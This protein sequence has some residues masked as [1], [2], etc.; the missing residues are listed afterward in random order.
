MY[1]VHAK[2]REG[3]ERERERCKYVIH[4]IIYTYMYLHMYNTSKYGVYMYMCV[5]TV[6]TLVSA[7]DA[8]T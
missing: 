6:R 4:V 1:N 5:H 7:V 2:G 3:G 8:W